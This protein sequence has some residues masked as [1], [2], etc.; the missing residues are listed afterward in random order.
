MK[1]YKTGEIRNFALLGHASAGKT[2]LSEA[3]LVNAGIINRIGS[4]ANGST[5][6]DY[7]DE[8]KKRQISIQTS[9]LNCD[10]KG[11]KLNFIDTPGYLD[12]ISESLGAIRATD[13]SLIVIHS[14]ISVQIGTDTAWNYSTRVNKSKMFAVNAL[15]KEH[16]NFDKVLNDIFTNFSVQPVPLTFPVNQGIGF[17]QIVDVIN[18]QILTYKTDGSGQ[19]ETAP[20]SGA[21]KDKAQEYY[22][23][24]V[25]HIAESDEELTIKFLE[26]GTLSAEEIKSNLH[27][28]FAKKTL[29]PLFS[30]A[31][32]QNIGIQPM[33][34]FIAEYGNSPYDRAPV[35]AKDLVEEEVSIDANTP[36]PVVFVFKTLNESHVGEMLLVRVFSGELISGTDLINTTSNIT[37]RVTQLFSINGKNRSAVNKLVCGDIGAIVKLKNTHTGDTL[38]LPKKALTLA[39]IVFPM[40]NIH[41]ALSLKA[42]GEEEKMAVGLAQIHSED[43]SFHYVVDPELHQTVISCQGDLHM[44][45]VAEK[46]RQRYKVDFDLIEPKVPFR[47]T[48][49]G[50]GE[51]KYR[52][53]KQSGGAGQFAEVWM[54]IEPKQRGEGVEFTQSLVGQNV[55]RA[56]VPSVEKGVQAACRE[57]I[58]AGYRIVDVKIDFYDGKMHPVDSKDIAFQIA[59]KEA[60]KESFLAAKPCLLEPIYL[61]TI[62]TPESCMGAVMGDL[63]SRRGKIQGMEAEG[64]N[65]VLKAMVP[66]MELYRYASALR[67][68]TG[69]RGIHT[70]SFSHY[71][72]MPKELEAKVIAKSKEQKAA[73]Q[74]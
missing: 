64:S 10:W 13:A 66:A 30:V 2:M 58:L 36:D 3:I 73:P 32:E 4:I 29:I 61:V 22:D 62:T 33:L 37:E 51:A 53:K 52:H 60:F 14:E 35:K 54:R 31:A 43:P 40:P 7:T 26:E 63:S 19:F 39:P 5:F 15:D 71:E 17:N 23:K 68:L 8:E 1:E 38:S 74:A 20:V 24:L 44:E 25:D 18:M 67:S 28:A 69:G 27:S 45:V 49:K 9:L 48:I 47:E 21:L 65:Q 57:G 72:E 50:K 16:A 56:F 46:I 11:K 34:D 59:G 42:K 12:F 6:S 41:A 70:E 55:D